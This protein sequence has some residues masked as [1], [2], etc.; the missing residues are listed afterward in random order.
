MI[1]LQ[2]L[3]HYWEFSDTFIWDINYSL[4]K[5][6]DSWCERNGYK[7]PRNEDLPFNITD[8]HIDGENYGKPKKFDNIYKGLCF[9]ECITITDDE[10]DWLFYRFFN[11]DVEK[12]LD[13]WC[14]N[15]KEVFKQAKK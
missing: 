2:I 9:W 7:R 13:D 8:S 6:I 4:N 14:E 1:K 11:Y 10:D 15:H 3:N 12:A 5:M